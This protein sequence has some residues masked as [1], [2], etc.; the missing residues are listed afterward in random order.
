[1]GDTVTKFVSEGS[2][3]FLSAGGGTNKERLEKITLE[4]G[5]D[6][7]KRFKQILDQSEELEQIFLDKNI[8][9]PNDE[10]T[11][12]VNGGFIDSLTEEQATSIV[13]Y[14]QAHPIA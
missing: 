3:A 10:A 7:Y 14:F 1:M 2:V 9:G 5:Q 13:L 11:F 6:S 8:A 12:M 4:I